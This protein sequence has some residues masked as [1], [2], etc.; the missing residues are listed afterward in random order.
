MRLKLT[1]IAIVAL[2]PMLVGCG[3]DHRTEDFCTTVCECADEEE[4]D[5]C[6]GQCIGQIDS[7]EESTGI[8]PVTDACF[9]C[10]NRSSCSRLET[11]CFS[12]ECSAL[13]DIDDPQ[14]EPQPG[15]TN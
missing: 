6:L 13:F 7:A 11:G 2:V 15:D 4:Q 9:A 1:M 12:T 5:G 3:A 10:V 8:S 14:P